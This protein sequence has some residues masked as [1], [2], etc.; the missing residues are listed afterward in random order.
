LTWVSSGID[1]GAK[2][3]NSFTAGCAR[4]G[5]VTALCLTMTKAVERYTAASKDRE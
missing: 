2:I 1:E 3:A 4:A 5:F